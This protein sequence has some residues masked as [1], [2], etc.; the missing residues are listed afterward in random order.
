MKRWIRGGV[1]H[2]QIVEIQHR[3]EVGLRAGT[4]DRPQPVNAGGHLSGTGVDLGAGLRLV[5]FDGRHDVIFAHTDDVACLQ[6]AV[7][8]DFRG[9]F[10]I[11]QISFE[12]VCSAEVKHSG[13]IKREFLI[14]FRFADFGGDSRRKS[15]NRS[16]TT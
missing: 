14:C 2:E 9:S 11:V 12:D 3:S 5:G 13:F 4:A 10:R 1:L 6:P 7:T 8:Q 16:E 15:A